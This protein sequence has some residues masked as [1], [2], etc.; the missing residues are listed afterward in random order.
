MTESQGGEDGGVI[1]RIS[2]ELLQGLSNLF[3]ASSNSS[4]DSLNDTNKKAAGVSGFP[5]T[6]VWVY[7]RFP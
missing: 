2:T 3:L 5:L 1:E 6:G 4:T 7:L